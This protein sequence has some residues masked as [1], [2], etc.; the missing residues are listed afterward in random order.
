MDAL[1]EFPGCVTSVVAATPPRQQD[2]TVVVKQSKQ[3]PLTAAL[4]LWCDLQTGFL[5]N[6]LAIL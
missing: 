5:C 6:S 1:R 4:S 2:E 3:S